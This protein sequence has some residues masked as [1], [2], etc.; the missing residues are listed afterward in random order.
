MMAEKIHQPQQHVKKV[1][2]PAAIW[3]VPAAEVLPLARFQ[4]A[5][6]SKPNAGTRE[7]K[8]KTKTTLVRRAQI[9]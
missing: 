5:A 7:A 9:M 8:I 2:A 4:Y 6:V 1:Q 3:Y